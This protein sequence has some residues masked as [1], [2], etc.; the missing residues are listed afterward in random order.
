[1]P[2]R[3][4]IEPHFYRTR[5]DARDNVFDYIEMFYNPL[6]RPSKLIFLSP[7]QF[8]NSALIHVDGCAGDFLGHG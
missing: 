3:R 6:R 2:R 4:T 7:I 8:E 5:E 1:M